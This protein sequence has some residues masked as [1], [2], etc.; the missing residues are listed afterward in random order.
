MTG[1]NAKNAVYGNIISLYNKV[2][3]LHMKRH[4]LNSKL[5][6]KNTQI[7]AQMIAATGEGQAEK[8]KDDRQKNK[9]KKDQ[10]E[11][12]AKRKKMRQGGVPLSILEAYQDFTSCHSLNGIMTMDVNNQGNISLQLNFNQQP[13]EQQQQH[14]Q[15]QHSGNDSHFSFLVNNLPRNDNPEYQ[16]FLHFGRASPKVEKKSCNKHTSQLGHDK[17]DLSKPLLCAFFGIIYFV[18]NM[19]AFPP[20]L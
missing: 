5:L 6:K 10:K 1:K 20:I 18:R 3:V 7:L 8:T 16:S 19:M 2:I 12:A 17:M 11:E 4:L 14:Q 13:Q 15:Q 9:R